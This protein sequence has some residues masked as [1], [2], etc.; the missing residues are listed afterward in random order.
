MESM[1]AELHL[2]LPSAKVTLSAGDSAS[3]RR[4]LN[5]NV[6]WTRLAKKSVDCGLAPLIRLAL[7]SAA[8]DLVPRDI[9]EAFEIA[10]A[11]IRQDNQALFA[12]LAA[13]VEVL[14]KRG[15]HVIPLAGP[16]LTMRARG[17]LD[18]CGSPGLNI[19]I[20]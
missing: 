4:R 12:E 8:P 5:E 17:N 6:D 9:L 16:A 19:A 3:I 11:K 7:A 15:I 14:A 13:V 10:A 2:L 1:S 20:Q 18:F